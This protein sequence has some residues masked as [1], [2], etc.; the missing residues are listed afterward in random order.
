MVYAAP[1][2]DL[3]VAPTMDRALWARL[4]ELARAT[5]Y[6]DMRKT[7]VGNSLYDALWDNQDLIRLLNDDDQECSYHLAAFLQGFMQH[8]VQWAAEHAVGLEA[9]AAESP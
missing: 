7:P 1:R 6:V 9:V 2:T 8:V 4:R 3:K 5:E